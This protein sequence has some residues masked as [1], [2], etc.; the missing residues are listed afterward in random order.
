M[1]IKS[2]P[3]GKDLMVDDDAVT[4]RVGRHYIDYDRWGFIV[5]CGND[6]ILDQ[7]SD[8]VLVNWILRKFAKDKEFVLDI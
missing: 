7:C 4:V 1:P 5:T 2:T 8:K 6:L 3:N